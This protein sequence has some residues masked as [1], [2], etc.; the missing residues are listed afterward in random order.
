[1]IF[2]LGPCNL[3]HA[4]ANLFH[5]Q[6]FAADPRKIISV[7]VICCRLSQIYFA[8]WNLQQALAKLFRFL[9]FAADPRK[10]ISVPAICCKISQIYFSSCILL[11]ALV[12]LFRSPPLNANKL[13][14]LILNQIPRYTCKNGKQVKECPYS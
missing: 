6:R 7:P 10:I 5:F 14:L 11:Q 8:S 1:M 2:Y 9:Q 4:L 3:L 13:L 12:K